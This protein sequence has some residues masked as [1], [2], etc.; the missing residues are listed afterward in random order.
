VAS[1]YAGPNVSWSAEQSADRSGDLQVNV[2]GTSNAGMH[3]ALSVDG[4][5][6]AGRSS[7]HPGNQSQLGPPRAPAREGCGPVRCPALECVRAGASVE[8]RTRVS[9]TPNRIPSATH[10][11]KA[12]AP[13]L[14]FNSV[15]QNRVV[16]RYPGRGSPDPLRQECWPRYSGSPGLRVV[17]PIRKMRRPLSQAA[18]HCHA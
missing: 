16:A 8:R 14:L 13:E 12:V 4:T 1:R 11:P 6:V 2:C 5:V 7:R 3:R 15:S 10:G 18:E 17:M 9:W